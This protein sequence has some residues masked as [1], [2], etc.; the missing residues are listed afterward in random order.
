[1][2]NYSK[3]FIN[4]LE[5][6][7]FKEDDG[8]YECDGYLYR[9][10][11]K[12]SIKSYDLRSQDY[13]CLI[14]LVYYYPSGIG[15]RLFEDTVGYYSEMKIMDYLSNIDMFKIRIRDN[16]INELINE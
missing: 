6:I 12:I 16:K 1:M 14:Q 8:A 7:G 2:E 5:S 9:A 13:N 4:F 15:E 11:Y 3:G 10:S